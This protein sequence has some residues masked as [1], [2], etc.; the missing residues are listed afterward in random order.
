MSDVGQAK[1]EDSNMANYGG[2]EM[3]DQRKAAAATDKSLQGAG[4]KVGLEVWRVENKRTENDTPDFGIARWPKEDYGSF[5]TGDSY[6]VLNTYNPKDPETGKINKDKLAWDVHFWLGKE[7][8]IDERG[9]AA[10]KTVEIDDLLDDGPIQ[11][12]E[13][14]E[15][16]S[17]LF[18]GYFNEMKYMEGGIESGFRKV[19]P[20][21]YK[22]RLLKVRRT[23]KTVRA[24]PCELSA[25][26][27]NQGDAFIL[28]TGKFVYIWAGDSASPFEKSKATNVAFNMV[29]SRNGKAKLKKTIDDEFWQVL[30]GSESDVKSAEEGD[31]EPEKSLDK[32]KCSLYR[33]SDSTGTMEVTPVVEEGPIKKDMLDSNDVFLI[34]STVSVYAWVGT[35]ASENER[36]NAIINADKLVGEKGL[37]N[38]LPLTKYVEG[39]TIDAQFDGL[40]SA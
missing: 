5:Y 17:P 29:N 24:T 30:G 8:S 19:K 20:E 39:K 21:E 35:G 1:L 26:S 6:I 37:P 2:K 18:Q 13:V 14:Q 22:P 33:V 25:S 31:R 38:T 7:T 40:F 27:M 32:D 10:Y 12:R 23:K 15:A 11:H 34:V 9:V 4:T 16:E 3:R 36:R 28:D